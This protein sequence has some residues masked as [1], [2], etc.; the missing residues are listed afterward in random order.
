MKPTHI[1]ALKITAIVFG[2][3]VLVHGAISLAV[4]HVLHERIEQRLVEQV[5]V[6]DG[7]TI[8]YGKINMSPISRAVSIEDLYFNSTGGD[9]LMADSLGFEVAVDRVRVLKVDFW[10]LLFHKDIIIRSVV[11]QHPQMS[12]HLSEELFHP[13]ST[14]ISAGEEMLSFVARLNVDNVR[15]ENAAVHWRMLDSHLHLDVDDID[16]AVDNLDFDFATQT[17]SY[18]DSTYAVS[19]SGIRILTPDSLTFLS[20]EKLESKNAG[21]I[22]IKNFHEH[23]TVGYRELANR[24]H[25]PETWTAIDVPLV[26]TSPINIIAQILS[27]KVTVDTL[28]AKVSDMKVFEDLRYPNVDPYLMPQQIL[29]AV[30]VPLKVKYIDAS[31]D[32]LHYTMAA[33]DFHD[34]TLE[35]VNIKARIKDFGNRNRDEFRVA[36][37]AS[38]PGGGRANLQLTMKMNKACDWSIKLSG[39]GLKG[40]AFNGFLRPLFGLGVNL[41]ID[42]VKADYKGNKDNAAGDFKML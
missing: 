5:Q 7:K 1:K 13:Q 15:I 8:R 19:L 41:D 22:V 11:I 34:G 20:V 14:S 37:S 31:I 42:E 33:T 38:F 26:E 32:S 36:G 23:C 39:K 10:D 21:P 17:A 35:I 12:L 30:E 40:S 6:L 18:N 2:S 25:L 16:L 27:Q 28:K 9:S 24:S 3:L 4:N 29:M